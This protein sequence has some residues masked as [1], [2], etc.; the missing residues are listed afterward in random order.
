MAARDGD[1]RAGSV[2]PDHHPALRHRRLPSTASFRIGCHTMKSRRRWSS[3]HAGD[4]KRHE[5]VGSRW[6]PHRPARSRCSPSSTTICRVS[7]RRYER[8]RKRY[9][10]TC[11]APASAW[12]CSLWSRRRAG[13]WRSDPSNTN[14]WSRARRYDDAPEQ[15]FVHMV[16]SRLERVL[17][18]WLVPSW[19][20]RC[21]PNNTGRCR[22]SRMCDHRR[23]KPASNPCRSD[24]G[25]GGSVTL[26][27]LPD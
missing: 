9:Q 12:A 22:A 19:P 27:S 25:S 24:Y 18:Y 14:H 13:R 21:Y 11:R 7:K 1:H 3:A 26:P 2:R 23:S 8:R 10:T 15:T 6:S 5:S 20:R 4:L 16:P 17:A